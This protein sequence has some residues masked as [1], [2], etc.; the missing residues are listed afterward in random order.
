M[1]GDFQVK[2]D[3]LDELR[4]NLRALPAKL[5]KRALRNALA[6]GARLV[7]DAARARAPVLSSSAKAVQ[8]GFRSSGLVRKSIVVR[9]SKASTRA[10]DVGVFVNVR[11]AKGAKFRTVTRRAFGLVKVRTR[12]QTRASSRGAK[13]PTDPFYWRFLEFG[14]KRARQFKFLG[15]AVSQLSAALAKFK[16]TLAPQ[17]A[18]LNRNPKEP[19]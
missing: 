2:I 5:R 17:I 15:G 9:T 7:R 1:A 11:P 19:L 18:R 8:Q 16:A 13:S 12:T 10:G 4:A 6:A 14:T 3:G